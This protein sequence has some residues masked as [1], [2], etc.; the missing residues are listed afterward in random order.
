MKATI[1]RF[2]IFI[3][4]VILS[5]SVFLFS[6]CAS[7]TGEFFV[8]EFLG[9]P[10]TVSFLSPVSENEKSDLVRLIG[11]EAARIDGLISTEN[12]ASDISLFNAANDGAVKVDELTYYFAETARK[13]YLSTDGAFDPAT[14]NLLDLWGLTPRFLSSDYVPTA[15]YDR[16][17]NPDGSFD[18]PAERYVRAFSLLADYSTVAVFERDGEYFLE[19][20]IAPVEVDGAVYSQKID[21]AGVAKGYLADQAKAHINRLGIAGVFVSIGGS[22]LYLGKTDAPWQLGIVDPYSPYRASFATVE[23]SETCCSTSGV[24]ENCY[25][26]DG[27]RYHHVID[28]EQGVPSDSDVV[29]ATVFGSGAETDILSTAAIVMGKDKA[30]AYLEGLGKK[31]VILTDDDKVYTNLDAIRLINQRFSIIDQK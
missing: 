1:K 30:V 23:V 26:L 25:Y 6:G 17:K 14:Y 8:C 22:S 28:G 20:T 11:K 3:L 2:Y 16:V 19:K 31:Y 24:Y 4:A 9:A 10:V 21:L 12:P 29:S 7:V 15:P 27:V 18:L 5:T 13:A